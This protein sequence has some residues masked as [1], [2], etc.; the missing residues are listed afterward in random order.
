MSQKSIEKSNGHHSNGKLATPTSNELEKSE[1]VNPS[2]K[3]YNLLIGIVVGV[4]GTLLATNFLGSEQASKSTD[5]PTPVTNIATTTK[6][7]Q[8]ITTTT[9]K[10]VNVD[11]TIEAT[12]T[13]LAY[14][15]IPVTAQANNL[16]IKTRFS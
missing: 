13:V 15:L 2:T 10:I 8:P 3:N 5:S 6:A 7:R 11:T 14:E 4:L 16:Q 12:G 1:F 9:A